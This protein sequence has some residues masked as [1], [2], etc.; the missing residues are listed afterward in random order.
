LKEGEIQATIDTE[1]IQEIKKKKIPKGTIIVFDEAGKNEPDD[2]Q[3]IIKDT[4]TA[5]DDKNEPMFRV[6]KMS[7]T[8]KGKPFSITTTFPRTNLYVNY[9]SEKFNP[10]LASGLNQV[11]LKDVKNVNVSALKAK[12][13]PHLIVNSTNE[14]NYESITYGM[15]DGGLVI[16]DNTRQEGYTPKIQ[17]VFCSG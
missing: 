1:K 4:I 9:V 7:A 16:C 14:A 17:N 2:Y 8:F 3:E 12:N 13:I 6:I 11:F 15:P 10:D 5:T